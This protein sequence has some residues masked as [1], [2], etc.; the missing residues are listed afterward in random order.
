MIVTISATFVTAN[1]TSSTP[2]NTRPFENATT[3]NAV[4]ITASVPRKISSVRIDR[5]GPSLHLLLR[6]SH[7][8]L[9]FS[10]LLAP[11][12]A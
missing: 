9:R 6:F 8:A 11:I 5:M 3:A 12:H 2:K 7:H 10:H 4:M 1:A